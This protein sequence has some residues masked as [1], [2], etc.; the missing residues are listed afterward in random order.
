MRHAR[1][2]AEEESGLEEAAQAAFEQGAAHL[3]DEVSHGGFRRCGVSGCD[4]AGAS[5]VELERLR[6]RHLYLTGEPGP[7]GEHLRDNV[8]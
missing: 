5:L 2:S 8:G 7:P 1:W 3:G 6:L 4:R